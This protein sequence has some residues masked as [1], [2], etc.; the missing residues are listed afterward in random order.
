MK[1]LTF[2]ALV[3]MIGTVAFASTLGIPWYVD[4]AAPNGS[5]P[6][7]GKVAG[8]AYGQAAIVFLKNTT[9]ADLPCTIMYYNMAG[10]ELGPFGASTTGNPADK[11]NTFYI[12]ASAAV[13]FRPVQND[14]AVEPPLGLAI[15]NRPAIGAPAG[16]SSGLTNIHN[17]S[18]V[19]SWEGS[20]ANDVQ[21]YAVTYQNWWSGTGTAATTTRSLGWAYLLPP[22]VA[23]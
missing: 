13:A 2:T 3:L 8:S 12:P 6:P 16:S 14:T 1:K 5:A 15:P 10:E 19:I 21:G 23:Q 22:G 18:I 11:D 17:G 4:N 7:I 9:T 20:G